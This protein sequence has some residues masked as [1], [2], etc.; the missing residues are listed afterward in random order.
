MRRETDTER[1]LRLLNRQMTPEELM[2]SDLPESWES[3]DAAFT[4]MGFEPGRLFDRIPCPYESDD[5]DDEA[6]DAYAQDRCT[7][8]QRQMIDVSRSIPGSGRP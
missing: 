8:A 3:V 7:E 1:I 2:A 4:E 6:L 5:L